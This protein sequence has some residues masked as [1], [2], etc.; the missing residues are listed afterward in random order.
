MDQRLFFL[1]NRDWTTPALDRCMAAASSFD[2]WLP[3][4]LMLVVLVA[5]KGQ[6]HARWFLVCLGLVL[7]IND[8]LIGNALKHLVHR[9]RP[10]QAVA[11]V[12]QLDLDHRAHPRFVALW[13]PVDARVST[14]FSVVAALPEAGRSFPSN[15]TTNNFCAATVLTI[16]YRRRGWLWF[17]VAVLVGYSRV[18]T[19]AHWPGDVL[20][21]AVLAVAW[22]LAALGLLR[23]ALRHRQDDW[24]ASLRAALGP[25]N[26]SP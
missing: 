16:F 13:H 23:R 11:G 18:Y 20:A 9:P 19:G 3:F 21:S 4:L 24:S 1:I 17:P 22:T 8:A 26:H 10:F 2:V 14:D 15:H 7:T 25:S 5:W 6:A 12:R